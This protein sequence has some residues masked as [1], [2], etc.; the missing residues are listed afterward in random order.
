MKQI[1]TAA[2]AFAALY[3]QAA[4]V[5]WE[6]PE[7]YTTD[8]G[9]RGETILN[10][11]WLAGEETV[12][13]P[14][15]PDKKK[16]IRTFRRK[17]TVPEAWRGRQMYLELNG[18]RGEV[19]IDGK[20]AGRPAGQDFQE[21]PVSPRTD[22][23]AEIEIEAPSIEGDVVLRSIPK[24]LRIAD[25]YLRTSYRKMSVTL[26]VELSSPEEAAVEVVIS[27]EPDGKNP[28]LSF[29]L[30]VPASGSGSI[31]VPWKNPELWSRHNPRLYYYT[32]TLRNR[33]GKIIDRG[34]PRSFGFREVWIENGSFLV[35]GVPTAICDDAWEG[36]MGYR[37]ICIPQAEIFFPKLKEAGITGGIR[38]SSE[39]AVRMAD[40][41]GL[42]LL[43]NCGSFVRVNIWDPKSGLTPM[44]GD[45]S[46]D[47]V[48]RRV[49]R[50]REHPSILAWSSNTAYALASM[51]PEYAGQRF[52]SWEYF[53]LCRASAEAKTAQE[54]FRELTELVRT[55]D[56]ERA[57][58]SPN[59]PWSPVET[60]TRYLCDNLDVQERE[61]F[62]DFWSRSGPDRKAVWL[63][64]FG[65][66]FAGHQYIRYIDHQM[67]HGGIWP[68]IHLENAARYY[69]PRVYRSEGAAEFENYPRDNYYRHM[70]YPV[71]QRMTADNVRRIW[72]AWRTFGVSA[73]A[74]HILNEGCFG[75]PENPSPEHRFGFRELDDPR[76]P[77]FSVASRGTFPMPGIDRETPAARA[78]LDATAFVAGFIGGPDG[79]FTAKDHLYFS[80]S[81][82]R[83]NF[84]VINDLDRPAEVNGRWELRRNGTAAARGDWRGTVGA[85]M[86]E[87]LRFAIEFTAPEVTERTDFELVA[88]AEMEGRKLSDTFALT[89]FPKH[90]APERKL[91]D[92]T[93]WYANISDDLTHETP[94]LTINRDNAELLK[95]AGI[96]AR[97]L[98]GLRSY[99]WHGLSPAAAMEFHRSRE[100]ASGVPRPGD[101]L[102]LPARTLTT[103]PDSYQHLLRLLEKTG[104]DELVA[105]G[106]NLLVMEQDLDNLFGMT[107][108]ETRP[109]Q[110][111]IAAEG[112]PVFDGLRDSDL[113]NWSGESRLRPAI[114][115]TGPGE[116]RF[117]ERIWHVSNTNAVATRTLVR[118][119]RGAVRA[120]AVCGFDLQESPLLEVAHGRGRML[121]CQFDISGRY[122][123][124]PAATQLFDN[125]V[126]YLLSAPAPDPK[127]GELAQPPAGSVEKRPRLFQADRPAGSSGWGITYGELFNREAIY[128]DNRP[129]K[130]LPETSFPAFAGSGTEIIRREPGGPLFMSAWTPGDFST[131]WMK[132]KAAW[133]RAALIV[134]QNGSRTDGPA[135]SRQGNPTALYPHVWVEGFVHPYTADIW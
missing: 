100:T 104:L 49:K 13:V 32:L 92:R 97:L 8:N 60:A 37:N 85:G 77:G 119:Q 98:G 116:Q 71:V 3:V 115:P 54:L 88:E 65:V 99:A 28:A 44:N 51:H 11:F 79:R 117:P 125:L 112:H 67:P 132:R 10:G 16:G 95:Q 94:H 72:R 126:G 39:N 90:R 4:A 128:P 122:G 121:F 108:E 80:G 133:I 70:L 64:E 22:E 25:S 19:R 103:A 9:F 82:V 123:T 55:V 91:S 81:P 52:N 68:K 42:H 12:R 21:Y 58:A 5:N 47:D 75:K 101:L 66:P 131:G 96:G 50:L 40:R 31:T 36:S 74:H 89:I 57:V 45:E 27:P 87:K 63:T 53:P 56:P 73:S 105:G 7:A 6:L 110:A 83:K 38:C 109:R 24:G 135:L 84:I 130:S 30:P 106:L 86:R 114:T 15:L 34:L 113:S 46:R 18:V 2:A 76:R 93:I 111:F 41:H 59:G 118:P 62:F 134:N 43:M 129:V 14:A 23:A 48:I 69:G 35:N 107:T 20:T 61:E 124:D 33:E 78:Y 29:T 26:D 102:I 127:R 17:F 120:L 1:L